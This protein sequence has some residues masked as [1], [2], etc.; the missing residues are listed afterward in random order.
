M[1]QAH[2]AAALL[3]FALGALVLIRRKGTP[4]HRWLGRVWVLLMLF[5]AAG[6]FAIRELNAPYPSPIHL[7]SAWTIVSLTAGIYCI[8][9]GRIRAHA[10]FMAGTFAGLAVAGGFALLPGRYIW[11]TLFG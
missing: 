2:L 4:T 10:G 3:A 9:K 6:S 7:L 1:I 8:R 11:R 5:I